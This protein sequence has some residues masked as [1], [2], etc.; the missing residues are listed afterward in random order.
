QRPNHPPPAY[1]PLSGPGVPGG[2]GGADRWAEGGGP[3]HQRDLRALPD[4]TQHAVAVF[5]P[6]VGHVAAAGFADPQAEQS[7]HGDECE[8]RR[9]VRVAGRAQQRLEL[10][11]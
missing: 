7:E 2:P 1:F 10:Q 5:F 3:R 9:V 6:E 4:G 8:V 11:V